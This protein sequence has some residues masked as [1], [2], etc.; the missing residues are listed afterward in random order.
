[1]DY[2]RC[3]ICGEKLSFNP[4]CPCSLGEHL[5][6][7]HPEQR[8]THFFPEDTTKK[9]DNR[10][11]T[12]KP[13]PV[14]VTCPECCYTGRPCIRKQ[15]NKV[16]YSS[17]GAL[18]MLTC[19]PLCFLPFLMPEG[20]KIHLYCKNCGTFLGEY[21]R[22]TGELKTCCTDKFKKENVPCDLG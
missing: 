22:K 2:L 16:A 13:G 9:A 17:F 12:W 8:M 6:N 19:W 5:I 15:R 14:E 18:C 20:S 10:V 7:K 21:S 3:Q 4:Y 1:M 11:E